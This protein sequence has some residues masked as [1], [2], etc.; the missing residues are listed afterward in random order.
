MEFQLDFPHRVLNTV[1]LVE[2]FFD[3][4]KARKIMNIRFPME[5]SEDKRIWSKGSTIYATMPSYRTFGRPAWYLGSIKKADSQKSNEAWYPDTDYTK[6]ILVCHKNPAMRELLVYI[7]LLNALLSRKKI[8]VVGVFSPMAIFAPLVEI[9]LTFDFPVPN[10][11]SPKS[12]TFHSCLNLDSYK[13]TENTLVV[14][15]INATENLGNIDSG[16]KFLSSARKRKINCLF[17]CNNMSE[18]AWSI[19]PVIRNFIL[20]N[21]KIKLMDTRDY[22]PFDG[23]IGELSPM[24][25]GFA[26][27]HPDDNSSSI[28]EANCKRFLDACERRDTDAMVKYAMAVLDSYTDEGGNAVFLESARQF[29]AAWLPLISKK[30]EFLDPADSGAKFLRMNLSFDKCAELARDDEVTKAAGWQQMAAYWA[31]LGNMGWSY[32][33]PASDLWKDKLGYAFGYINTLFAPL[34]CDKSEK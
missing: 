11:L 8:V 23:T 27:S 19:Y 15:S 5:I 34:K 6:H 30:K 31:V 12:D 10:S 24:N 13:L 16:M 9:A 21:T 29:L 20:S 25:P 22:L 1:G 2:S 33:N 17:L 28:P 32:N 7:I 4:E 26:K 18:T 3:N 14:Y